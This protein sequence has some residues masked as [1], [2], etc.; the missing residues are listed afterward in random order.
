[1]QCTIVYPKVLVKRACLQH[2]FLSVHSCKHSRVYINEKMYDFLAWG[3]PLEFIH[4]GN[5]FRFSFCQQFYFEQPFILSVAKAF[6][7]N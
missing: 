1:M 7:A 2:L 3:V 5:F 6:S 4:S